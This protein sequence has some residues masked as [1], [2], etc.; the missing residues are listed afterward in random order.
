VKRGAEREGR[1]KGRRMK[2][3][4]WDVMEREK[5]AVIVA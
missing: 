2:D 5:A 4:D 3:N 1:I